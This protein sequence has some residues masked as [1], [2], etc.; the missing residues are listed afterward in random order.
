MSP[1]T[2]IDRQIPYASAVSSLW[3]ARG[4]ICHRLWAWYRDTCM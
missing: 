2:V 3:C 4:Q 1:K